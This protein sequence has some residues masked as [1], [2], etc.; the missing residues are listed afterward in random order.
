M[1]KHLNPTDPQASDAFCGLITCAAQVF[2]YRLTL[3]GGYSSTEHHQEIFD[4]LKAI[5]D[6][7]E[8]YDFKS[9]H[10]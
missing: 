2:A 1:A 6:I 5:C 7:I 3:G 8:P 10:V 4:H 9:I